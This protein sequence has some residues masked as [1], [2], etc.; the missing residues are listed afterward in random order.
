MKTLIILKGLV[1]K[2]K[3]NWVKEQGL[4]LFFLDYNIVRNLYSAPELLTSDKEGI[5]NF[6]FSD[7]VYKRFIEILCFRM[8]KGCLIVLDIE[9]L[10]YS[11]IENLATIF[12]YSVFW[13]ID[14]I[15]KDYLKNAKNYIDSIYPVKSKLELKKDILNYNNSIERLDGSNIITEYSQIEDYW[16]KRASKINTTYLNPE[17][18]ITHIS[19]IHSNFNIYQG[20]DLEGSSLCIFYGDYIDGPIKGGSRKM[21]DEVLN[22][23]KEN[24][25]W[26]EGNHES[27]LRKYLGARYMRSIGKD[28][29]ADTLL[30]GIPEE[31]FTTTA[32]EFSDIKPENILDYIRQLNNKLE[33]FHIIKTPR[34]TFICTHS[35]FRYIDQISPKY[36]GNVVY[37]TRNIDRIDKTFSDNRKK[38][39]LW[40]IHAHCKYP[41]DW[42]VDKYSH[43]LN[44]DPIDEYEVVILTQV[45]TDFKVCKIRQEELK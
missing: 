19:D 37:G 39:S 20:L 3:I 13:T 33:L 23:K 11:T 16:S 12:G 29:L 7:I 41:T 45:N 8:S 24:L 38:K 32:Q 22:N 14:S 42:K 34:N 35:G 10:S 5:L 9:N 26:L 17:S 43:V 4:D 30:T 31:F 44:I 27:R 15:P 21:L 36:I 18:K 6:S 1:K 2:H 40:S 28:T 25:V